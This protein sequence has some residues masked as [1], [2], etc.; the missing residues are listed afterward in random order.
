MKTEG[1]LHAVCPD[2]VRVSRHGGWCFYFPP[3]FRF[4]GEAAASAAAEEKT[5]LL[6][7]K[8]NAHTHLYHMT[9]GGG[10]PEFLIKEY[11]YERLGRRL[12]HHRRYGRREFIAHLAALR[13]GFHVPRLFAYFEKSFC[14]LVSR[15]G[16]IMEY[17]SGF[18]CVPENRPELA[19]D[20]IADC[21]EKGLFYADL[22]MQNIGTVPGD[23]QPYLIDFE[24][25]G[26]TEKRSY[27]NLLG[28]V[29]SLLIRPGTGPDGADRLFRA[30]SER[31]PEMD[32]V[33]LRKDAEALDEMHMHAR[34]KFVMGDR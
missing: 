31:L 9:P 29:E 15:S 3:D 10:A 26:V 5:E 6:P 21:F 18:R 7:G 13:L 30:L 33:R 2:W 4:R 1:C 22:N 34:R 24:Q 25:S 14:G 28:C 17:L 32:P 20:I 11:R 23:P 19:A 12:L 16:I 27:R 8:R